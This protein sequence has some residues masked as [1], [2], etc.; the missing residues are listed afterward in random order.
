MVLVLMVS[1]KCQWNSFYC[2]GAKYR[3]HDFADKL[4]FRLLLQMA[5]YTVP[6]DCTEF[7]TKCNERLLRF[8]NTENTIRVCT[9]V[10]AKVVLCGINETLDYLELIQCYKAK[11]HEFSICFCMFSQLR[12]IGLPVSC[13]IIDIFCIY[14]RACSV[15]VDVVGFYL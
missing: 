7:V 6:V 12:L 2:N 8:N 14:I 9:V 11:R 13:F 3:R 10:I 5:F 4:Q 15:D 1:V